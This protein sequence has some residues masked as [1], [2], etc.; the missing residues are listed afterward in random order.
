MTTRDFP[1]LERKLARGAPL[2]VACE[3]TGIPLPEAETYLELRRSRGDTG[4]EDQLS[5]FSDEALR[6]AIRTLKRA[7]KE[8]NR[9]VIN[10]ESEYRD[11]A[12]VSVRVKE[13]V[14]DV[15]A[16]KALLKA[17][18]EVRRML[19]RRKAPERKGKAVGDTAK[20]LFDVMGPW[21]L[22]D[23]DKPT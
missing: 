4:T 20:D 10:E 13:Q 6:V 23:P 22:K 1:S 9:G 18:I 11:G 19:E 5:L 17:G 3:Q 15:D 21:R 14:L 16:A 2:E 8:K 12:K 7:I